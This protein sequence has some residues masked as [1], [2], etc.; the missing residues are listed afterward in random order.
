[1]TGEEV[2]Q[3][4]G[5][6]MAAHM[7]ATHEDSA[8]ST[9]LISSRVSSGLHGAGVAPRA[10]VATEEISISA[11]FSSLHFTVSRFGGALGL[12]LRSTLQNPGPG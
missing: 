9:R 3:C 8:Q 10:R 7:H 5:A 1:M 11:R 6:S 12:G 4:C 2:L